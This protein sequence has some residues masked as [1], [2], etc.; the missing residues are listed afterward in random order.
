[1]MCVHLYIGISG[2]WHNIQCNMWKFIIFLCVCFKGKFH[3]QSEDI[4]FTV[5]FS[6]QCKKKKNTGN[7]TPNASISFSFHKLHIFLPYHFFFS[8]TKINIFMVHH[9]QVS[10]LLM[11]I[12]IPTITAIYTHRLIKMN[13]N[14]NKNFVPNHVYFFIEIYWKYIKKIQNLHKSCHISVQTWYEKR[15]IRNCYQ[16]NDDNGHAHELFIYF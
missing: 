14:V 8:F 6:F 13:A 7:Y 10:K 11:G 2:L 16:I 3:F 15:V 12:I 5:H 9:T 4:N 1:M